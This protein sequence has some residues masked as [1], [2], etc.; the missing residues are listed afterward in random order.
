M[1]KNAKLKVLLLKV[2]RW[3]QQYTV[4]KRKP[5]SK[6]TCRNT[7]TTAVCEPVSLRLLTVHFLVARFNIFN[8]FCICNGHIV[9]S[10]CCCE[11]ASWASSTNFLGQVQTLSA[12]Y[13]ASQRVS[14]A[15]C[16]A[17]CLCVGNAFGRRVPLFAFLFVFHFQLTDRVVA[18]P[19]TW[20]LPGLKFRYALC[21]LQSIHQSYLLFNEL[22][23][24]NLFA[25]VSVAITAKQ[26]KKKIKEK[27]KRVATTLQCSWIYSSHTL[28]TL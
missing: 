10:C 9:S 22:I 6:S 26:Q 20:G 15:V 8:F 24:F 1:K 19:P 21:V 23:S 4:G 14:Q 17:Q 2:H 18:C 7:R 5:S 25:Q 12:A 13:P 11:P 16:L 27:G 28:A 3:I